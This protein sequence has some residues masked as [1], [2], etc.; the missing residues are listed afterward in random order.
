MWLNDMNMHI[1]GHATLNCVCFLSGFFGANELYIAQAS[2]IF[3]FEQKHM[4][5]KQA[6][7][8]HELWNSSA[9]Q[10]KVGTAAATPGK[11]EDAVL[12]RNRHNPSSGTEALSHCHVQSHHLCWVVTPHHQHR[13]RGIEHGALLRWEIF[14][15]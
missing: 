2:S 11:V 15:L 6:I 7:A 10:K 8:A 3:R 4:R 1:V 5:N 14:F 12:E 13:I 9:R